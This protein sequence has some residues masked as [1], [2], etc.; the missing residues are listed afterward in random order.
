MRL[1]NDVMRQLRIDLARM[2]AYVQTR[3]DL[4][5]WHG[6]ADIATSIRFLEEKIVMIDELMPDFD[7]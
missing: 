5:D 7:G 2:E 4:R 3:V 1:V 6:L